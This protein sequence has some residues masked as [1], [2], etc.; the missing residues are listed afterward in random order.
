VDQSEILEV[1]DVAFVVNDDGNSILLKHK[2]PIYFVCRIFT[3]RMSDLK[4]ISPMIL[5]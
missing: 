1:L 4:V 3:A 5:P 2:T